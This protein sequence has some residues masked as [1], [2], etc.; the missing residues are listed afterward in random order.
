MSRL[1]NGVTG[2][3]PEMVKA[4]GGSV[5]NVH[6]HAGRAAQHRHPLRVQGRR[7]GPDPLASDEC[8]THNVRASILCPGLVDTQMTAEHQKSF[9][10]S[11]AAI[12]ALAARQMLKRYAQPQKIAEVTVFLVSKE[13]SFMTGATVPVEA[14]LTAW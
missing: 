7:S 9:A 10:S 11:Q 13:A 12:D 5:V 14:G 4:G 2:V 3:V 6:R 1:D 8:A